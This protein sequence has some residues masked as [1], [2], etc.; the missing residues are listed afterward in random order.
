L[1]DCAD[2]AKN[3]GGKEVSCTFFGSEV[4]VP[5]VDRP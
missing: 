1:Q 2:K 4:K 3:S 5:G